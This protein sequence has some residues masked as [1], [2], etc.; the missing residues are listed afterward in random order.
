MDKKII[1]QIIQAI[2]GFLGK[3]APAELAK[4]VKPIIVQDVIPTIEPLTKDDLLQGRDKE[5][6]SDY[7]PEISANLDKLLPILNK[8]QQAYGKKFT[9]NSGWRPPSINKSTPG[10]ALASKHMLGL[11]ADIADENGDIMRW[12]LNNLALMKELGV[13]M[14]DWRW[15]PTWTH[16]QIVAPKSGN[17]ILIPSAD[18]ALAPNRWAGKFD[19]KFN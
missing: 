4:P 1:D 10:A 15:T 14:E 18:P 16:F 6:A 11:A 3:N 7:T 9:I 13:Y 12:V 5:Y 2:M 19:A 17:R 8:I